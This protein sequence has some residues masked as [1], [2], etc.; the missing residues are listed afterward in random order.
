MTGTPTEP[1]VEYFD[2][3]RM[4]AAVQAAIREARLEHARL[5]RPVCEGRNGQ[6]VWLTPAEVFA[7]YGLDEHG[8]PPATSPRPSA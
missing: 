5:G 3:D 6:V 7:G 1:A 2:L 8:N 4:T